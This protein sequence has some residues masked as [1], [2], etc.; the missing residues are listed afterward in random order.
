MSLSAF[1]ACTAEMALL[2]P[3]ITKVWADYERSATTLATAGILASSARAFSNAVADFVP[4]ANQGGDSLSEGVVR[5]YNGLAEAAEKLSRAV[6]AQAAI[7]RRAA[8][9]VREELAC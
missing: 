2:A 7:L 3:I 4:E 8:E 5:A 6:A 9:A 1:D